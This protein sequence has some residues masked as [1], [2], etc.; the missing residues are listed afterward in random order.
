MPTEWHG[1]RVVVTGG[2]SGIGRALCIELTRAG[3]RVLACGTHSRRVREMAAL[4]GV[5]AMTCDVTEDEDVRS[6]ATAAQ[7]QLGGLDVLVNCAGIQRSLDVADGLDMTEVERELA[8]NLTAPIRVTDALLPMLLASADAAIVNV[9]SI[10][11][12]APKQSAPVYCA[13]KAGLSAWT[14]ALRYQLEAR[15]V[16]VMELVPPLVATRMT[17]GRD[18]GA[19]APEEVARACVRGLADRKTRVAV[20]KARMAEFLDAVVP[21]LLA[22]KL[23]HA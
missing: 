21:G 18:A 1:R 5:L 6:L 3:A 22:R 7:T 14:T 16:L 11:A 20:G 17:Q 19:I 2:T 15:G 4:E 12:R 8:V 9:S 13:A 10:L 23:R